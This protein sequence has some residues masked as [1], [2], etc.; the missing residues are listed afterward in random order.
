[1]NRTRMWI[2]PAVALLVSVLVNESSAYEHASWQEG[3]AGEWTSTN[4]VD[5]SG[6]PLA[7]P[8]YRGTNHTVDITVGSVTVASQNV[9]IV[10]LMLGTGASLTITNSRAL[11]IDRGFNFTRPDAGTR[12]V[13]IA[14][15]TLNLLNAIT[16]DLYDTTF[17]VG[18]NGNS[19]YLDLGATWGTTNGFADNFGLLAG[20]TIDVNQGGLRVD[21]NSISMYASNRI[22]TAGQEVTMRGDWL[23]PDRTTT[24]LVSGDGPGNIDIGADWSFGGCTL[25]VTLDTNGVSLIQV[26]GDTIFT[27]A[28]IRIGSTEALTN[29]AATYDLVRVPT[30]KTISTNGL[31]LSADLPGGVA[32]TASLDE[33]RGGYDYLVPTPREFYPNVAIT[34]P[35]ADTIAPSGTNVTIDVVATDADG[36]ISKVE[37]YANTNKLGEVTSTPYSMVWSDVLGGAYL[38]K[39]IATDDDDNTTESDTVFL[40][41]QGVTQDGRNTFITKD[42]ILTFDDG[43][44]EE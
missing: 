19:G 38:L 14:D 28:T 24:F 42:M 26:G 21:A 25:E 18:T 6:D 8:G 33:D 23:N 7:A 41:V 37:F 27:N 31:S 4:W 16:N 2:C 43:C 11:T 10:A 20:V 17:T 29:A 15:G 44:V 22:E 12:P 40:G 5:T 3:Y 35:V 32:C 9:E 1:M 36:T 13:C 39:A 30:A 34:N